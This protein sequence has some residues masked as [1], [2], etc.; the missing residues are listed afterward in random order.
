MSR[1]FLYV[2]LLIIIFHLSGCEKK[3]QQIYYDSKY[4]KEIA[5]ARKEASVYMVI[6][7]VPGASFAVAKNGKLIYSEAIGTASK[8]LEV[9]ATRK[10]KFRIGSTSEIFTSLMYLMMVEEGL[11]HPDSS[12]QYYLPDYPKPVFNDNERVITLNQLANHTSGIRQPTSTEKNW[13]GLNVTLEKSLD[14]F[15]NDPLEFAPGFVP[16]SSVFNY[17]ILGLIMEKV[18]GIRYSQL[19]KSYITDSLQLA[20]TEIDNPFRTVIGRSDFYD[21]NIVAQ[22]VNSTFIDLRYRAPSEGILSNAEDLVNFGNALLYSDKISDKTKKKIFYT[23]ELSEN[24]QGTISN[25]WIVQKNL[26]NEIYY[27]KFGSIKGGGSI[28]L[29]IPDIELVVAATANITSDNEI[30]VFKIMEPFITE[31][32]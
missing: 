23:P 13:R 10:T 4:K 7:N 14:E 17:N 27:G 32:E 28:I 30:P 11:L 19:L 26:K 2:V 20:N 25:G 9:Q 18:T 15:K 21:F 22:A 5:K 6:N 24:F 3:T 16:S 1:I 29:I 8:D 31:E 12:I